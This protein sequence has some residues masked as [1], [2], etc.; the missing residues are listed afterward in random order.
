MILHVRPWRVVYL[1]AIAVVG[2]YIY[3]WGVA[4]LLFLASA[5]LHK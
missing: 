4:A 5:D 1:T 2:V 3:G